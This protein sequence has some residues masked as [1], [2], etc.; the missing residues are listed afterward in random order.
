VTNTLLLKLKT[1][2]LTTKM[3]Q[4]IPFYH[5]DSIIKTLTDSKSQHQCFQT[6]SQTELGNDMAVKSK[7]ISSPLGLSLWPDSCMS[8]DCDP[9]LAQIQT[10]KG[11]NETFAQPI[12]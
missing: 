1:L 2:F 3:S 7:P 8:V 4:N 12:Q 6:L 9:F 5:A 11:S 10:R